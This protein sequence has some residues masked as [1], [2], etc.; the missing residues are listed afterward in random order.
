MLAFRAEEDALRI[1]SAVELSR[2]TQHTICDVGELVAER[3]KVL[4]QGYAVDDE[5]RTLGMRCVAAPVFNNFGEAVVAVSVSGPSVRMTKGRLAEFG[6]MVRK[7]ADEITR[8]VGGRVSNF[9]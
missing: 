9:E 3:R 4:M 8:N 7:A 6:T 1:A 2:Y 5:E